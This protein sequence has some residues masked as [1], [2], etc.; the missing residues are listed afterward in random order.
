M[1]VVF[2]RLLGG[3]SSPT[4]KLVVSFD[5]GATAEL[6]SD[7]TGST[8]AA[9]VLLRAGARG[10]AG[11]KSRRIQITARQALP[12]SLKCAVSRA[13]PADEAR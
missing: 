10:A 4:E 8:D 2:E 1:L 11:W 12:T 13:R 6:Y 7:S 9:L 3:N 5:L